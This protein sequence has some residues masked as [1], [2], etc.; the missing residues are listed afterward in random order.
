MA[1]E[2]DGPST[3]GKPMTSYNRKERESVMARERKRFIDLQ[4]M[5]LRSSNHKNF[6]NQKH[7]Q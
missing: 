3:K 4:W 1:K 2:R 5:G 6:C 7:L